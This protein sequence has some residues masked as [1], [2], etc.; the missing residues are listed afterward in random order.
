MHLWLCYVTSVLFCHNTGEMQTRRRWFVHLFSK[1][2]VCRLQAPLF[3]FFSSLFLFFFMIHCYDVTVPGRAF[4]R[5][6]NP[7]TVPIQLKATDQLTTQ[8]TNE[9]TG[10]SSKKSESSNDNVLEHILVFPWARPVLCLSAIP[11]FSITTRRENKSWNIHIHPYTHCKHIIN[12][13]LY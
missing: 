2:I 11:T 13:K 12:R 10:R 4:F 1:E 8:L 6:Q 9:Q 7:L 3:F 5:F